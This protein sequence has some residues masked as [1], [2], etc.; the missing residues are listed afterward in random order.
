[1]ANFNFWERDGVSVEGTLSSPQKTPRL[2][3]T[4]E[5]PLEL[6]VEN[7]TAD[8]VL[9]KL[10]EDHSVVAGSIGTIAHRQVTKNP[11]DAFHGLPFETVMA[12]R[13]QAGQ[14]IP[15]TPKPHFLLADV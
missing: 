9:E 11:Y 13:E 2:T 12:A 4:V 10:V 14:D 3:Q 6:T 8:V 1:M 5:L 15:Q 7:E